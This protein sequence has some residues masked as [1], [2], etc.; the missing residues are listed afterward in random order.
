MDPAA[1]RAEFPVLE[2][3]AYMNAGTD[4]PL[5]AAAVK[6]AQAELEAELTEGRATPH[7]ER[8]FELQAGLRAG[9]ARVMG[10]AVEDVAL[11]TSTSEGIAKVMAGMD[12]G[13]GD[14]IVSS[15]QEHPG[16]I[17]PLKAAKELG[18]AVRLVPF[19]ELA[20]AVTATTTLVVCSHVGWV[21]G[22]LAPA[23]LAQLDVPVIL[24][25]AQGSGA[26]P[27][28]VK[29]LNCAAYAAAG[30]K[31][32][33]GADGSGML[34]LSPGWRD[35]I[36]TTGP[37]YLSFEDTTRGLESPYKPD[38]RRFD[39]PS[40]S[41]EVAALSL[42]ALELLERHG[43]DAVLDR[44]REQAAALAARLEEAGHTVAPRGDSTLV[45]W[46]DADPVSTVARLREEGI[47][48]RHLPGR[49]LLRASVGAWNDGSDLDRLLT[50][51]T[52]DTRSWRGERAPAEERA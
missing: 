32:L 44:G 3:V 41:R 45:A 15:D 38:A 10:C 30:Q 29:Q 43:L 48:V 36:R 6:F 52:P 39:T 12:L 14:E 37:S 13:P 26:V 4:G 16:V 1:L 34:Y 21:S 22:E 42:A 46:E 23:V 9:Y 7:F 28:D 50:A 11:T 49:P 19:Q 8:R 51:I 47:A 2:R 40:L 25:G 31:W 27:V 24:D 18:A 33:C 35:R 20:N 17:G 5:A